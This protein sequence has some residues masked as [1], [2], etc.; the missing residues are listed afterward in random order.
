VP[1]GDEKPN[2]R[3][4]PRVPHK[5]KTSV[6]P[7]WAHPERPDLQG[8]DWPGTLPPLTE[9]DQ[10]KLDEYKLQKEREQRNQEVRVLAS[11]EARLAVSKALTDHQQTKTQQQEE[12][13]QRLAP[14][15]AYLESL[16]DLTA[17]DQ[18]EARTELR[19]TLN[20]LQPN[21]GVKPTRIFCEETI[22]DQAG[23]QELGDPAFETRTMNYAERSGRFGKY[24]WR[25][26]GWAAGELT[27]D[28]TTTVT[29]EPPPG[30][31]APINPVIEDSPKEDPMEKFNGT[32]D[33]V[34]RVAALF[35]GNK[36]GMD[37]IEMKKL[38][39]LSYE[40]GQRAGKMEG[41][42][43]AD[44]EH[45]RELDDLRERHRREL[46]DAERR[47]MDRG[48]IEG[49]REVR[50]ELTPKLWRLEH[51]AGE[52]ETSV[53]GELVSHLGGP[54]A[55][56]GLV[57]AVVANLN[58][59]KAATPPPHRQP[60][61][62]ARQPSPQAPPPPVASNPSGEPTRAEH[63]EA[64][65]LVEEA[66]AILEEQ[67]P[68]EAPEDAAKLTQL[69]ELLE[70]FH[71][72]GLREGPLAPWWAAW[73]QHWKPNVE[74]IIQAAEE[75]AG[76]APASED[77]DMNLEGL[78]KELMEA[79]DQGKTD[80]EILEGLKSTVS[81]ETRAAWLASMG[82]LPLGFVAGAIGQG[83][84]HDRLLTLLEAFK[85]EA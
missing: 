31:V 69:Q 54:D 56:Q 7:G 82:T 13:R 38:E 44:R 24:E 1:L 66:A 62:A 15:H 55:F 59:P 75:H 78:R 52:P 34:S 32:L 6:L 42:L 39:A 53:I 65:G 64:M 60:P 85:G 41:Q 16:R 21:G 73:C 37:P 35:G 83:K 2:W 3:E 80:V 22:L 76:Q 61:P 10:K 8:E 51:A 19:L 67:I 49:A 5:V 30:Y 9:E 84:H 63:L 72:A 81:V 70:H 12:D 14:F 45:R 29:V 36:G 26:K 33:M 18:A 48:R 47:G 40:Q 43:E 11:Q 50:D 74:R 58:K 79:L 77:P 23:V 17:E 25:M 46:E 71:A 27:L 57:G 4:L 68:H 28:T 20:R